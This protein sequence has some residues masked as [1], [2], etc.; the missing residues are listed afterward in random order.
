M[1]AYTI[2]VNGVEYDVTVEEK[3]GAAAKK[4]AAAAAAPAPAPARRPAAPARDI[5]PAAPVQAAGGAQ[6]IL[7]RLRHRHLHRLLQQ[8]AAKV[9]L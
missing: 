5:A 6:P 9:L 8:Q 7:Q 3:T 4:A 1:K 2:T